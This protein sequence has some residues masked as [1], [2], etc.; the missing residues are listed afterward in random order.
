M[1]NRVFPMQDG[2]PIPWGVA[3][4]IYDHLYRYSGQSLERLAERGGFG[5]AEVAYM[6]RDWQ[7]TSN[8]H[9]EAC[10]QAVRDFLAQQPSTERSEG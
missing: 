1:S 4:A 10:V 3:Q 5:W 7:R 9:R 6:W 8:Q 2:P